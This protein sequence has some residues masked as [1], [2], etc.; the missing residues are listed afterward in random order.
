MFGGTHFSVMNIQLSG[1][2]SRLP[3]LHSCADHGYVIDAAARDRNIATDLFKALPPEQLYGAGNMVQAGKT[4]I[5]LERSLPKLRT[6]KPQ[7]CVH[8][9]LAE[10]K[11]K[12]IRLERNI[13]IQISDKII[14]QTGQ[15]GIPCLERVYLAS[16]IPPAAIGH[17]D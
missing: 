9:E 10:Q 8:Q 11:L 17:L 13:R 6:C 4:E 5:V 2:R 12:V 14:V 16:K 3:V 1:E 15:A 7:G